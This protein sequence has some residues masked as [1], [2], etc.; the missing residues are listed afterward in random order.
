MI[1]LLLWWLEVAAAPAGPA[2][3]EP[4]SRAPVAAPDGPALRAQAPLWAGAYRAPFE[5]NGVGNQVHLPLWTK[6][7]DR[8]S[9]IYVQNTIT[10]AMQANVTVAFNYANGTPVTGCG[11]CTF[12]IA[13]G[14][15]HVVDVVGISAINAN[16]TGSAWVSSNNGQPIAVAVE[17]VSLTAN[18]Y[19]LALYEGA[20]AGATML[21]FPDVHKNFAGAFPD[22]ANSLVHAQNVDAANAG[23][24]SLSVFSPGATTLGPLSAP[25][26]LAAVF[27]I[28]ASAAPGGVPLAAVANA[29]GQ[30]FAA[31]VDTRGGSAAALRFAWLRDTAKSTQTWVPI[32]FKDYHGRCSTVIMGRQRRHQRHD[33]RPLALGRLCRH[34]DAGRT[35]RGR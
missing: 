28:A 1:L 34:A 9:R 35:R 15:M 29:V 7:A 3:G 14:A 33:R 26:H 24:V 2:P 23:S 11:P 4:P 25:A 32:V 5:G 21:D 19:D 16:S 30:P 22:P 10:A 20:S 18:G 12:N 31:V 17:Q 13:P 8:F 6:F 27:D